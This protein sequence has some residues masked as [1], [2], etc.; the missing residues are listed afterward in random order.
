[1]HTRKIKILC[2]GQFIGFIFIADT[3]PRF[4]DC[5]VGT[6]WPF[7]RRGT[8]SVGDL[9]L[10]GLRTITDIYNVNSTDE[11]IKMDLLRQA[12]INPDGCRNFQT[13]LY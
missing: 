13:V 7:E 9:E 1:M 2:D 8:W 10:E 3:N 4:P 6:I 11:E 12:N 5:I